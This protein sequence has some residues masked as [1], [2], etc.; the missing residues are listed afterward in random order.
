[1]TITFNLNEAQQASNRLDIGAYENDERPK[2][3][4]LAN[5]YEQFLQ[6]EQDE[7]DHETTRLEFEHAWPEPSEG[8]SISWERYDGSFAAAYSGAPADG[9]T[10][11]QHWWMYNTSDISGMTWPQVVDRICDDDV[12]GMNGVSILESK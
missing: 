2:L 10:G 7:F 9:D 12:T 3:E 5:Q 8:V 1:M 11:D 4:Q 6:Q